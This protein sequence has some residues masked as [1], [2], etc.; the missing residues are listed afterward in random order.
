MQD[1]IPGSWDH[2]L[3]Q[4]QTL[5][6]MSIQHFS[7][8]SYTIGFSCPCFWHHCKILFGDNT[9][10]KALFKIITDMKLCINRQQ[11]LKKGCGQKS[12][13]FGNQLFTYQGLF[14]ASRLLAKSIICC[15][16]TDF[17]QP[18]KFYRWTYMVCSLKFRF[19]E[20]YSHDEG[21]I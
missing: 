4:R 15:F 19:K 10:R 11:M 18:L 17:C 3:S 16:Q 12:P 20:D 9:E 13:S 8:S 21:S 5:N 2:D 7:F 14:G 6:R 1:S